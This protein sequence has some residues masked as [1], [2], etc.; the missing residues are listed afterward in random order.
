MIHTRITFNDYA[1]FKEH[2]RE[3]QENGFRPYIKDN[4][5]FVEL[6]LAAVYIDPNFV[7]KGKE[8]VPP[9]SRLFDQSFVAPVKKWF[10]DTAERAISEHDLLRYN[11]EDNS[12]SDVFKVVRPYIELAITPE[13]R[14][15][16]FDKDNIL[17][18]SFILE[19]ECLDLLIWELVKEKFD[20][21]TDAE[22]GVNIVTKVYEPGTLIAWTCDVF[23]KGEYGIIK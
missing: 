12:F 11:R 18:L 3:L 13:E 21:L 4:K 14:N 15:G 10:K 20:R 16:K 22:K 7:L 1:A 23:F 5:I 9:L 6:Q 2:Y 19:C 17:Y 8:I